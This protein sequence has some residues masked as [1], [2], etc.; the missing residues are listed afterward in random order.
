M[1]NIIW[2]Q[3][4]GKLAVTFLCEDISPRSHAAE[5]KAS[6]AIPFGWQ[7]VGFDVAALPSEPQDAWRWVDGA[8]VVEQSALNQVRTEQIK[9]QIAALEREQQMPRAQREF[10]LLSMQAQFTP[11]QLAANPGYV[12]VKAFDDSIKALREQLV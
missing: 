11:E 7:A 12:A 4:D 1:K 9:L 8:V 6:A 3:P 5:L 2:Q 10:M